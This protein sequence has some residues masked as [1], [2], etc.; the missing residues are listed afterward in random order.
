MLAFNSIAGV[1]IVLFNIVVDAVAWGRQVAVC[2]A[3]N[4]L[5]SA[6]SGLAG[7]ERQ[8]TSARMT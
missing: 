4:A 1:F 7:T 5:Q 8:R 6:G 3:V 2:G